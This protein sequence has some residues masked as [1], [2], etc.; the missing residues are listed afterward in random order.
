LGDALW[1]TLTDAWSNATPKRRWVIGGNSHTHPGRFTVYANV[2]GEA[3]SLTVDLNAVADASPEARIWL[4][5]YMCGHEPD[6]YDFAPNKPERSDEDERLWLA[7]TEMFY[8]NGSDHMMV[9]SLPLVSP[10]VLSF[11]DPPA[12][13]FRCARWWVLQ[14]GAW[15]A[16]D[17][18]PA[19]ITAASDDGV[20][21]SW[22]GSP[23]DLAEE[24]DSEMVT[25]DLGDGVVLQTFYCTTCHLI[26]SVDHSTADD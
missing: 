22:P 1:V 11:M 18:Q 25:D 21:W 13:T 12:W 6:P 8:R 5:G 10:T 19:H 3:M 23:C 15:V 2:D 20:G 17:P 9:A 4:D 14:E 24:H 16:A 26:D 7:F